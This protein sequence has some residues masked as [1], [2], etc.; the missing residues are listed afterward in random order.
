MK[1]AATMQNHY[2]KNYSIVISDIL[3][4]RKIHL[5]YIFAYPF[6]KLF[7]AHFNIVFWL[8]AQ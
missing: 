4:F 8:P 2:L 1:V 6:K 5:N 7:D 3:R